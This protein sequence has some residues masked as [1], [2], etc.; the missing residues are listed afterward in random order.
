MKKV[1]V[2]EAQKL[3][4]SSRRVS[5]ATLPLTALF[6][7]LQESGKHVV[8]PWCNWTLMKHGDFLHGMYG[9]MNADLE[10][11]RTIKRGRADGLVLSSFK[12]DWAH[13]GT[14]RQ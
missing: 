2:L 13:Q 12:S 10:V 7:A 11:Q 3:G 1:G 6:W 4:L 5:R 14:W 9:S 8:G